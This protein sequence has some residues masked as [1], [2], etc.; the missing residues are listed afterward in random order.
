MVKITAESPI[1][2]RQDT[3]SPEQHSDHT[4][5]F[6]FLLVLHYLGDDLSPAWHGPQQLGACEGVDFI[7][8]GWS[9]FIEEE[10]AALYHRRAH[11]L[12]RA[13]LVLVGLREKVK[14]TFSLFYGSAI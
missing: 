3:V 11:L 10:Q 7:P 2:K 5:T 6:G 12:V 8:G 1:A 4:L 13:T 14:I 9:Q